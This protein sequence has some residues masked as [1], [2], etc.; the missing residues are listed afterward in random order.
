MSEF[1]TSPKELRTAAREIDRIRGQIE[2]LQHRIEEVRKGGG[3]RDTSS[4]A[5]ICAHLQVLSEDVHAKTIRLQSVRTALQDIARLYDET[6][7]KI[8]AGKGAQA[9]QSEPSSAWDKIRQEA[10]RLKKEAEEFLRG[11]LDSVC[12]FAGDPVNMS[13]GDMFLQAHPC[14]HT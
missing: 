12:M 13:T 14:S 10:Q 3:L 5:L 8:A 1:T 9:P 2:R 6:E 7:R 4:L 11:L